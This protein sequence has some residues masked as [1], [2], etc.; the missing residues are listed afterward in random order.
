MFSRDH[1]G[2]FIAAR[3]DWEP[4]IL[5]TLEGEAL[6]LLKVIQWVRDSGYVNV[7][8]EL[9]SKLVVDHLAKPKEDISEAG[10]ILRDCSN[11]LSFFFKL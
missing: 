2:S 4:F 5:P 9:D 10:A 7:I 3:T 6:G 11:V 1:N 8:F